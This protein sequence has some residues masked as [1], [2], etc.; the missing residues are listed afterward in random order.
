LKILTLRADPGNSRLFGWQITFARR[1][2]Y[3]RVG[4]GVCQ[5]VE[6]DSPAFLRGCEGGEY[7]WASLCW[8]V[9]G[10]VVRAPKTSSRFALSF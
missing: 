3:S 9:S 4:E 6:V 1:L 2:L 8:P 7:N 10:R 5:L